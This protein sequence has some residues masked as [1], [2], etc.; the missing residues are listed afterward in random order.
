[1][2]L[3][4]ALLSYVDYKRGL[5]MKF[6]T[7]PRILAAY[8]RT[9]GEIDIDEVTSAM[10]Q[11]FLM[12]TGRQTRASEIKYWALRGFY[13]FAI[14][15][16]YVSRSPLPTRMTTQPQVLVPYIYS[17]QELAQLL[18]LASTRYMRA[19]RVEPAVIHALIALMYGA[20]L[21]IS[22]AVGLTLADVVV[23][24]QQIYVRNTKFYKTRLVPLD[25][26]LAQA[27][28]KYLAVRN[29]RHSTAPTAPVFVYRQGQRLSRESAQ[30]HFRYLCRRAGFGVPG[31]IAIEPRLHDL[32]HTAAVHRVLAWYRGGRD[33]QALLPN[34]ATYL[35]H[36]DVASTQ[37]YLRLIPELLNEANRR[38][39]IHSKEVYSHG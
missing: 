2:K 22:E 20:G 39:A 38:F 11:R 19:P 16:R 3:G 25:P 27:L 33:V 35:G 28:G 7:E 36:K 34:L 30:H 29:Q 21:R 26:R 37:R 18:K 31:G 15:R 10:A 8:G 9:A 13:K 4:P 5:G 23:R 32:R 1:M 12:P 17:R 14:A 6:H 24:Q